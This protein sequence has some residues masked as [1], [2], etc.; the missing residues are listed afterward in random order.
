MA[1]KQVCAHD[2]RKWHCIEGEPASSALYCD[3]GT[4]CGP[5]LTCCDAGASSE[6]AQW[7]SARHGPNSRCAFEVCKPGGAACPSGTHCEDDVCMTDLAVTCPGSARG[8]CGKQ[9]LCEWQAGTSA[10][11]VDPKSIDYEEER[12]VFGCTR[13][14]D[15]ASGDKCCTST[16]AYWRTTGCASNCDI[17]NSTLACNTAKDCAAILWRVP[18]QWHRKAKLRCEPVGDGGPAWLKACRLDLPAD[19]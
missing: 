19:F 11:V 5:G 7:C 17:T 9:E 4:D 2:G 18:Q 15:C 8:R 10:C 12:G 14:Q 3:D 16:S 6:R 13:P 1:R